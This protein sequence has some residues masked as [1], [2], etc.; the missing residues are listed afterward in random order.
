MQRS[1]ARFPLQSRRGRRR[2]NQGPPS[3]ASERSSRDRRT[4][5]F[6]GGSR[7]LTRQQ[8]TELSNQTLI[9]ITRQNLFIESPDGL[10]NAIQESIRQLYDK[11]QTRLYVYTFKVKRNGQMGSQPIGPFIVYGNTE[12]LNQRHRDAY[13]ELIQRFGGQDAFTRIDGLSGDDINQAIDQTQESNA[14]ILDESEMSEDFQPPPSRPQSGSSSI[15]E[16][17]TQTGNTGLSGRVNTNPSHPPDAGL[18]N[19]D[20]VDPSITDVD[21]FYQIHQNAESSFS[22]SSQRPSSEEKQSIEEIRNWEP[23]RT[24]YTRPLSDAPAFVPPRQSVSSDAKS[25][26]IPQQ[27]IVPLS[28]TGSVVRSEVLSAPPDLMDIPREDRIR[29]GAS[30]SDISDELQ[31]TLSNDFNDYDGIHPHQSAPNVYDVYNGPG[32]R[33][34]DHPWRNGYFPKDISEARQLDLSDRLARPAQVGFATKAQYVRQQAQQSQQAR[35]RQDI[36]AAQPASTVAA[37]S[38]PMAEEQ[39]TALLAPKPKPTRS[40]P[41]STFI[42]RVKQ[43]AK[44]FDVTLENSKIR[45]WVKENIKTF[46]GL[47]A[48]DIDRLLAQAIRDLVVMKGELMDIDQI[49]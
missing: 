49:K 34:P 30:A 2:R 47:Q 40:Y 42:R 37:T 11:D 12:K 48:H 41:R 10:N 27:H 28:Q 26:P 32:N 22:E 23:D 43:R 1:S 45:Q 6:L 35:T 4:I 19:A 9:G 15:P 25:E 33:P 24:G 17:A 5:L 38:Q 31:R 16:A 3:V 46:R 36:A 8:E 18:E 13:N 7:G 21:E 14:I 44:Q 29:I 39:E 20:Q